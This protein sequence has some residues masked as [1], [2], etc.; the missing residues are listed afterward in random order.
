[1]MM[2]KEYENLDVAKQLTVWPRPYYPIK[3]YLPSYLIVMEFLPHKINSGRLRLQRS[4]RDV[5]PNII[6][7]PSGEL[8][9]IL[10][11]LDT[12]TGD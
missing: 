8:V 2:F 6:I 10:W 12:Y 9:K 3:S 11:K 5:I 1:M 7:S 4:F